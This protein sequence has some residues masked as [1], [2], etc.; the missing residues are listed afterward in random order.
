MP[1]TPAPAAPHGA[2]AGAPP[3]PP[4]R[5]RAMSDDEI[6]AAL[7]RRYEQMPDETRTEPLPGLPPEV[8]RGPFRKA[9]PALLAGLVEGL[10]ALRNEAAAAEEPAPV[11][12]CVICAA[13]EA[14]RT[15]ARS[16][17]RELGVASANEG[18][19]QHPHRTSRTG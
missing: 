14:L 9:T 13:F 7:R 16:G 15:A 11:A 18:I 3:L 4:P 8:G 1:H 5:P 6:R 2:P 12:G 17:G 19:R 10:L